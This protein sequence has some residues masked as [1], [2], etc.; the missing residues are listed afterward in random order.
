LPRENTK[1]RTNTN[2]FLK[3]L[4][5]TRSIGASFWASLDTGSK[6]ASTW[7]AGSSEL[8]GIFKT[9]KGKVLLSIFHI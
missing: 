4:L 9:L 5:L 2:K 8:P 6:M 3:V 7:N 1:F